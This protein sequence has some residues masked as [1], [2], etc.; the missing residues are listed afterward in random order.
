MPVRWPWTKREAPS[1]AEMDW[2]L[3]RA[4]LIEQERGNEELV[5]GL[6]DLKDLN[7]ALELLAKGQPVPPDLAARIRARQEAP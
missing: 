1:A 5:E 6:R 3:R 4:M 7:E 2:K